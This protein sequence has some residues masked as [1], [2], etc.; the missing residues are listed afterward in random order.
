M[1]H[2]EW[3]QARALFEEA[4]DRS[5]G[6]REAFVDAASAGNPRVRSEVLSLLAAHQHTG[7]FLERPVFEAA[8]GLL[9]DAP[10]PS[11]A[12]RRL[13]PYLVQQEI[14]RGGMG[15]VYLAD[16]TRLSRRVAL[17]AI[18][19]GL[20]QDPR[21]RERLRQEARAA[22]ALSHPN[23]A[24]VYA[25]EEIDGELYLASE[26]VA[27]PTLRSI[28][29]GGP[30]PAGQVIEIAVQLARALAAA[31]AQGV[32]HRDLKPDNVIRTAAGVIK[33]LDFGIAKMETGAS[34]L[35]ADGDVIGTA[36][37]MAP[38]QLR[39]QTVD[40]RADLFAFGVVV[41]ELA[42][43]ASLV[44]APLNRILATTL[45]RDPAARHASTDE[46]VRELEALASGTLPAVKGSARSW[47]EL[48]QVAV[49]A[50]EA[51]LVIPAWFIHS[52]L[53]AGW[54]LPFV[55]AMLAAAAAGTTIRLHLWFTSRVSP[56]ELAIE[57]RRVAPWTRVCDAAIVALSF[58]AGLGIAAR[59][60]ASSLIFIGAAI[61]LGLAAVVIEPATTRAAFKES[62]RPS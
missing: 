42:A 7:D 46:L 30:L 23:I 12:G 58:A 13:G 24:T 33:I 37:Y 26:Y 48:H 9:V 4:L 49:S 16:D 55:L 5:P 61:T 17:K 39:G 62:E 15:V 57:R 25:L 1:N 51:L 20:S 31:H 18:A 60:P 14:G 38:E 34:P 40:F 21:R 44:S 28:L 53:P 19:P 6:D 29:A 59:H 41:S 3:S 52:W 11:L 56:G 2:E 36:G 10:A 47:W 50:I 35:T 27:G 45:Q 22:A 8:A 43:A 54:G 32:V